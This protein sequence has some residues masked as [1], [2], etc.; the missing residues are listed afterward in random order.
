MT[1]IPDAEL[2]KLGIKAAAIDTSAFQSSVNSNSVDFSLNANADMWN[3][4]FDIFK[5]FRQQ[6]YTHADGLARLNTMLLTAV[7]RAEELE[8][9][10]VYQ[11]V[12]YSSYNFF[13][14]RKAPLFMFALV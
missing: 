9:E 6:K 3:A 5:R 8:N 10:H 4:V 13:D 1:R 12:S 7:D 14:L 11:F 2:Q